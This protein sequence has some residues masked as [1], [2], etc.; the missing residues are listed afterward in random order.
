MSSC[1][2]DPEPT[3]VY[4]YEQLGRTITFYNLSDDATS[5]Q[6]EFGD[7]G[8]ST[9]LSPEYTYSENGTYTVTL[10]AKGPGGSNSITKTITV[11][12]SLFIGRWEVV[13]MGPIKYTSPDGSGQGPVPSASEAAVWLTYAIGGVTDASLTAATITF[14]LNGTIDV[15]SS[16]AGAKWGQ[17]GNDISISNINMSEGGFTGVLGAGNTTATLTSGPVGNW[18]Q[19]PRELV[20]AWATPYTEWFSVIDIDEI[21]FTLN[22]IP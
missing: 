20:P 6:W 15:N 16:S 18:T 13:G 19:I 22:A 21:Q 9:E 4:F 8:T 2:K 17:A 10:T 3:A 1:E 14:N 5:C 7:G 12:I 11:E